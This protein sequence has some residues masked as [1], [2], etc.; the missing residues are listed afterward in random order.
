M[1][2]LT[3]CMTRLYFSDFTTLMSTSRDTSTHGKS[4]KMHPNNAADVSDPEQL[5]GLQSTK[6]TDR[7]DQIDNVRANGVGDHIA[8]PQLVVCGDQSVGKSSVL[9]G[10]TALPFPRQDGVCTKSATEIILRHSPAAQSINATINPHT[11]RSGSDCETLCAY[12]QN[13]LKFTQLSGVIRYYR[14]SHK[15]DGYSRI[16]GVKF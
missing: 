15:I 1:I 8:L 11:S 12:R 3:I 16:W 9:E 5:V 10:V 4:S 2:P 14:G 13:L 6:A 7:L